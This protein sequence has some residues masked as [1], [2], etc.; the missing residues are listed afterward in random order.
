FVPSPDGARIALRHSSSYVPR[1]LAVMDADGGNLRRLTDTRSPE[2]R[3]FDWLQ[4]QY[5]QVPS[6]HGAGTIGGRY[7]GPATMGP[8]RGSPVVLRVPGAGD[9]Q[10]GGDRYANS[11]RGQMFHARLVQGGP[12]ALD[13]D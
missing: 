5:V 4:P 9:V 10:S 3:A 7:Y 2:Y 1:Q 13:L 6:K 8:G 11:S 12:I